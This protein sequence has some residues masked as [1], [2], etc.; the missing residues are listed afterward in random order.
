MIGC[1]NKEISNETRKGKLLNWGSPDRNFAVKKTKSMQ[2]SRFY[3]PGSERSGKMQF[4]ANT[5]EI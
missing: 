4:E 2:K 1:F 3:A 5:S